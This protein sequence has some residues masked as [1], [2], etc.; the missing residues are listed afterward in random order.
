MSLEMKKFLKKTECRL[1]SSSQLTK[2][3]DLNP[4][5]LANNLEDS[6]LEAKNSEIFPLN[7]VICEDCKHVQLEHVIN[8]RILF[9]NYLYVSGTSKVFVEHLKNYAKDVFLKFKLNQ[10][11]LVVEI[12]SNDGTL[13]N[14]F[15]A[16]GVRIV[17]VEPAKNLVK[18]ST[19]KNIPALCGYFNSEI[20]ANIVDKFGKADIIVA[21][22]VLAHIDNLNAVF[23]DAYNLLNEDGVLIFEVSYLLSV[24]QNNLF[25][26]IYHEHIDYHS[27]APL[28]GFV[29]KLD[30][31]IIDAE[32]VDTHGG[33]IRVSVAKVKSSHKISKNVANLIALENKK[34]IHDIATYADFYAK[35][36]N[37]KI[38]IRKILESYKNT[39]SVIV[40]FGVPAKL[41]TMN[42]QLEIDESVVSYLVDENELK[43]RKFTAGTGI[44]IFP[45]SQLGII[46]PDLVIIMAWNFHKSILERLPNIISKTCDVLIPLPIP[47]VVRCESKK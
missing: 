35:I 44:E 17:G 42:Y 10:E 34:K 37:I 7:L 18:I 27:V 22:N 46:K 14:E 28:M 30:M 39:G 3:F 4:S 1:C 13:L 40:G 32:M 15:K 23:S 20:S 21:N 33:S 11:S 38:Q 9:D 29:N 24:I 5:S 6:F 2:I 12:G 25:D 19:D 31:K 45:I 47:V 26:T 43:Q 41:T 36:D 16:L 8:P